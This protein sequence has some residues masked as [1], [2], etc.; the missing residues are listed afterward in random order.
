MINPKTSKLGVAHR[1]DLIL[2]K[3][4]Y[5]RIC[6]E[7]GIAEGSHRA[8]ELRASAMA[9][10]SVGK[11]DEASLYERLRRVEYPAPKR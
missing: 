11:L 4:V 5:N 6:R 9:L 10:I 2:L 7:Q 3:R 1:S 8:A